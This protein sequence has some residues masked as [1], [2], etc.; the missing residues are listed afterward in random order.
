MRILHVN[1][2]LYRRGGAEG[3]MFD[4][5]ALQRS[6]GHEVG[7][8]GMDHPENDRPL[9]LE[10][11]FAP[12]VELEP[13]PGGLA[14]V[15]AAAR[16]V[17]SRS[18]ARG[19]AAALEEFRPDLVH[20]HNIYHQLSPSILQPL[21]RAKVPV[22]MTLHD[23][24]LACPSY[25][26][27]DHG[28][29]CDACVG[30]GTWHATARRCK[31]GSLGGSA[32]LTIES[33]I[34]RALHAYA[35]VD[36]FV[37]PSRFLADVML[38][39]GI[40]ADRLSVVNN[41]T[42]IPPAGERAVAGE[43]FVYAGRLSH[44]KGVE[45]AIRAIA[46]T[47]GDAVLHV[48]GDGPLRA[49]LEELAAAEAPGR[50][51]FHGRLDAA[52]LADLLRASRALVLPARW[53]ENQPMIIL[54]AYAVGTPVLV[55]DLGGLPE[56]VRDGEQGL[57]VPAND[58]VALAAAMD[59]LDSDPDAA[60]AMGRAGRARLEAEFGADVHLQRLAAVYETAARHDT[61]RVLATKGPA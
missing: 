37:C 23:Y 52:A 60:L 54:E 20:C 14:G 61:D 51:R 1:K 24:K 2:F 4:V 33:G 21:R 46:R 48:A 35:P 12:H 29:P 53:Y 11:T 31:G 25:Q 50:V 39:Q 17:W 5:A 56:L 57:V 27:L 8:F 38:R 47:G 32:V 40:A 45:D 30:S 55:T 3:Y 58:P 6:A 28:A 10:H 18:S 19:M 44:E 13:A 59:R 43:G 16:M 49:S 26:M 41:F 34:H 36:H 22:V 9:P 15:A 7:F 42:D